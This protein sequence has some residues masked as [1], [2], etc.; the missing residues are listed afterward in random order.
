MDRRAAGGF[1]AHGAHPENSFTKT[2]IKSLEISPSV[3]IADVE[4]ELCTLTGSRRA[5]NPDAVSRCC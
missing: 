2:D 3:G 1:T 5:M 4:R